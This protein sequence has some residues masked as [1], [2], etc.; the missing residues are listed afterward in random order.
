MA[1]QSCLSRAMISA[2]TLCLLIPTVAACAE[3]TARVLG[4]STTPSART[5][6]KIGTLPMPRS[7]MRTL[8]GQARAASPMSVQ[9]NGQTVFFAN[10]IG[11]KST[12]SCTRQRV[13]RCGNTALDYLSG[14]LVDKSVVCENI[15][16]GSTGAFIGDCYA[17]GQ[18]NRTNLGVWMINQGFAKATPNA[19][20]EFVDAEQETK[21]KR[22]GIFGA[23]VSANGFYDPR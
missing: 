11:L 19:P 8:E 14:M 18:G 6:A 2:A 12:A 15:T 21:A 16:T 7:T 5:T 23:T 10:I 20:R 22:S 3:K 13:Y 9:I 17:V 1:F 4:P